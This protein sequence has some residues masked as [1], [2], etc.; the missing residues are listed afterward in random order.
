MAVQKALSL[1][2]ILNLSHISHT[3]MGLT[4]TE[5]KTEIWIS[6]LSFIK[7]GSVFPQSIKMFSYDSPFLMGLW[8]IFMTLEHT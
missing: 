8:T 1:T 7:S 6:F 3:C 5:I 2:K 4:C